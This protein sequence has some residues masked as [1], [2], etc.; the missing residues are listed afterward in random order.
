MTRNEYE[1]QLRQLDEQLRQGI[2][3]LQT[4][5]RQQ[6]RA[7]EMVWHLSGEGESGMPLAAGTAAPPTRAAA[8]EPPA[9]PRRKAADEL[10]D[11][12]LRVLPD[13]PEVFD[14]NQI[15]ERLGYTPDRG[16]IHRVLRELVAEGVLA[17]VSFGQGRVPS[18]YRKAQA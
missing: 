16:S 15:G 14:R 12:I 2:E 8:P 9:K 5:H 17:M 1:T 11:E 10:L 7:L 6:V 13:L 3:L 4:A 18:R